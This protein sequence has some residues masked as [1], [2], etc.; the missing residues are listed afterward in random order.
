MIDYAFCLCF[1]LD[2]A[3]AEDLYNRSAD[4]NF[5]EGDCKAE[6]YQMDLLL[7]FKSQ[8][9][10]KPFYH[11]LGVISETLCLLIQN[12]AFTILV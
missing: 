3:R 6:V 2:F 1:L 8:F 5:Y 11:F 12:Q 7:F 9:P 10:D 4:V